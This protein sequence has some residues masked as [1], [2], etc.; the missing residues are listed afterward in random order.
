MELPLLVRSVSQA[1][2]LEN[3]LVVFCPPNL[4]PE[5]PDVL[6]P[7]SIISD[8]TVALYMQAVDTDVSGMAQKARMHW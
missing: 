5:I 3:L 6:A 7:F 2:A 8:F 4:R 1:G